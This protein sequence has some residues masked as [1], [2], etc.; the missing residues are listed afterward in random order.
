M[1]GS[2]RRRPWRWSWWTRRST[3]GAASVADFGRELPS[4]SNLPVSRGWVMERT[5]ELPMLRHAPLMTRGQM[6][7]ANAGRWMR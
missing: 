4:T 1:P 6:H 2:H 5:R 3:N 7:R